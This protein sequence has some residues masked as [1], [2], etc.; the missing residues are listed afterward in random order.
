MAAA[1]ICT[2]PYTVLDYERFYADFS[3]DVQHLSGG[4]G[5]AVGRGWVCHGAVRRAAVRSAEWTISMI[6]A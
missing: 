5:V 3:S 1:F 2:S 4:H 6:G